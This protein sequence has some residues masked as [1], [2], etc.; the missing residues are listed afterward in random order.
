MHMCRDKLDPA[1]GGVQS[2]QSVGGG[3]V[4]YVNA[5]L[6]QARIWGQPLYIGKLDIARMFA[7]T[8]HDFLHSTL[9]TFG[10]PPLVGA[11]LY[12]SSQG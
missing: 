6:T 2:G 1:I 3:Q 10:I 9:L 8:K 11:C 4:A 5:V 12:A 7:S